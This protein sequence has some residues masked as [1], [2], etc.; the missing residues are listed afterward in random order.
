M[1]IEEL[2]SLFS[3]NS[4]PENATYMHDYMRGKFEY[5]GIKTKERR[6]LL[7]QATE[8]NKEELWSCFI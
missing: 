1:F 6:A 7:K 2:T 8:N 3:E 5:Y 4:N